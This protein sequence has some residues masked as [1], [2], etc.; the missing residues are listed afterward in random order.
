M[1]GDVIILGLVIILIALIL[2]MRTKY[3]SER[4]QTV[5]FVI[6]GIAIVVV[7]LIVN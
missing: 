2:G 7:G 5:G 4:I 1:R 6:L 3:Y